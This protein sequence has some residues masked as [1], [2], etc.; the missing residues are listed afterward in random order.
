MK[1]RIALLFLIVVAALATGGRVQ[2]QASREATADEVIATAP[3]D[4]DGVELFRV[5]GVSSL[6]AETRAQRISDAIVGAASDSAVTVDS[7]HVVE[8]DNRTAIVAG[9]RPLLTVFDADAVL[10]QVGR[11]EL[12]QAH[13]IQIRQ[14]IIDYRAA[15]SPAALRRSA[16]STLIA[17]LVF[18]AG[19]VLLL[20]LWRRLDALLTR[21]LQARIHTVGIQQFEVMRAD[22]IWAALRNGLLGLRTLI[23]L[24]GGLVYLGY[25]LARWPWTH[26]LSQNIV[27]FAM[28]PLEVMGEGIVANI[29]SLVFLLVLFFAI[30]LLL[31]L[32]RLFFEAVERGTVKLNRF[33]PDW[34]PPTYKIIRV[35]VIAFGLIVAYPYIP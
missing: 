25:V 21:R 27:G 32:I 17:T 8:S 7:V 12:A 33:D 16:V 1:R 3:V 10:E 5:R 24:A 19:V 22:R 29:P 31:R 6:P 26:G 2:A 14:S 9:N 15:R 28:H 13:M 23:L 35:A 30:R 20:W 4:I 18:A 34:A 11:A